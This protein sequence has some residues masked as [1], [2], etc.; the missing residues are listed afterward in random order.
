MKILKEEFE[1]GTKFRY[2]LKY[3]ITTLIIIVFG[4]F[5]LTLLTYLV[6]KRM[7]SNMIE[8]DFEF[9]WK[10]NFQLVWEP[11]STHAQLYLLTG[12]VPLETQRS[13]Y[14]YL[15]EKILSQQ[16][17]KVEII[18]SDSIVSL[19]GLGHLSR[20]PKDEVEQKA[21]TTGNSQ[22]LTKEFYK[23]AIVPIKAKDECLSCHSNVSPGDTLGALSITIPFKDMYNTVRKISIIVLLLG[24]GGLITIGLLVSYSFK[25]FLYDPLE[26]ISDLLIAASKGNFGIDLPKDLLERSDIVGLVANS[27][28]SLFNTIRSFANKSLEYSN[29][30]TTQ[31]DDVFRSIETL[32]DKLK[33][34]SLKFGIIS[35]QIDD[36]GFIGSDL[37]KNVRQANNQVKEL[38]AKIDYI[39]E[40]ELSRE[41]KDQFLDEIQK[42]YQDILDNTIKISEGVEKLSTSKN[43]LSKTIDEIMSMIMETSTYID[44]ISEEAYEQL[45]ISSYLH[46]QAISVYTARTE[47]MITEVIEKELDRYYLRLQA[48]VKGIDKLDP[49]K[50]GDFKNSLIGQWW[51]SEE[52]NNF[53]IRYSSYDFEK[54]QSGLEQLFSLGR[55]IIEAADKGEEGEVDSLFQKYRAILRRIKLDLDELKEVLREGGE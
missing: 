11:L 32:N 2:R 8:R 4:M 50:H 47:Q 36:I 53:R 17:V 55:S 33:T 28:N 16:Q 41:E 19:Y 52:G 22:F 40:K 6:S 9:K 27:V 7:L 5:I 34:I 51:F 46:A 39:A 30:L 18:V 25:K 35:M 12:E 29:K 38:K 37:S 10:R 42:L 1:R 24:F 54:L 23:T 14:N 44:K 20:K 43:V 48:H 13:Y 21:F 3:I 15:K 31:I 45:L 26:K 49:M